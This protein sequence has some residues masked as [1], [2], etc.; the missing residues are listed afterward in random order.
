MNDAPAISGIEDTDFRG[1][2]NLGGLTTDPL[3]FF[4]TDQD[5]SDGNLS[6]TAE[7]DNTGLLPA[8]SIVFGGSGEERTVT[9]TPVPG[10]SGQT[11]V[12]VTVS[13]GEL[14]AAT[15][16]T[17]TVTTEPAPAFGEAGVS[18]S[19]RADSDGDNAVSAGDTLTC[20]AVIPNTGD[21]DAEGVVF[22]MPVPENTTLDPESL[23]ASRGT[24]FY[25]SGLNQIEWQGDIPYASS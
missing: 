19:V 20:T 14:T 9:L 1:F 13:D 22:F 17:P 15:N 2:G 4:V 25:N 24:V 5:A 6:L 16:F 3:P 7:S 21:A 12:T 10:R 18:F 23:T 11:A 8:G